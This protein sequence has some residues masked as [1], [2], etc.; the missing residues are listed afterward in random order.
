MSEYQYYEFQAI[1]RPLTK[2]EMAE[3][4]ALSTRAAITPTRFVNVYHW[5]DFK[6]DPRA[7]VER[8]YD[9]FLYVA[10]WGSH[11]LMLRLPKSVLDRTTVLHYA[12]KDGPLSVHA[13]TEHLI[14]SFDSQTEEPEDDD[15]G[16]GWLAALVPLRSDIAGGDLRALY[17]GW[18]RCVQDDLLDEG[19]VEPPIP[20]GLGELSASLQALV[21]FLR[22]EDDLLEAAAEGSPAMLKTATSPVGARQ[23]LR[24]L[25]DTE[26][27]ALLLRLACGDAQPLQA[28]VRRRIRDSGV[29]IGTGGMEGRRRTV[30]ELLAGADRRRQEREDRQAQERERLRQKEAAARAAYLDRLAGRQEEVWRKV[31]SLVDTKRPAEY[32]EAIRLL[33]DIR[34]LAEREH[35]VEAFASRLMELRTRHA[36]KVSLL[37]RL[38]QAGLRPGWR[39]PGGQQ[40]R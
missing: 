25:S 32:A 21:E 20:P 35:Q 39:L 9:A 28:E 37:D 29:A 1:D 30:G 4:R 17:L 13:T 24:A 10:N 11:H 26:K 18:L 14:L 15:E 7:L 6:G 5:G 12:V 16:E 8:C 19:D 38:N 40:E 33:T 31:D 34:D 27:D 2:Q 3:V 23:W 22:L 36:R